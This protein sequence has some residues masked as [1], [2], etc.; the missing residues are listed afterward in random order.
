[1]CD[2]YEKKEKRIYKMKIS[3]NEGWTN[4]KLEEAED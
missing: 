3:L 4:I 1:M 2:D